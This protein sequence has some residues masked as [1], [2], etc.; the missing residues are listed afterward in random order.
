MAS[1]LF[2]QLFVRAQIKENIKAPCHWNLWREFT[3]T[4]EF[5]AQQASNAEN[6]SIW[7]R[8]H[9]FFLTQSL[10]AGDQKMANLAKEHLDKHDKSCD[11]ERAF[12]AYDS[13]QASN[14]E[15]SA[16]HLT[17]I[18]KVLLYSQVERE[19]GEPCGSLV[20]YPWLQYDVTSAWFY[21]TI[22]FA[23][24]MEQVVKV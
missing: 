7:W 24:E 22:C 3:V 21:C 15:L 18:A 8:H 5:P 10:F 11:H 19:A 12:D 9:D 14:Q 23:Q 4:G 6:V 1:P 16:P 17:D 20:E 13:G 2:A